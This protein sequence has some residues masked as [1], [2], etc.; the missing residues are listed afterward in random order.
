M[1]AGRSSAS[2]IVID[3]INASRSHAELRC[4]TQGQ[5]L[6][7]DLGSTNGTFVNGQRITTRPLMEGDRIAIGTTDLMFSLH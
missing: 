1:I 3:D 2:D 4:D 5:W 7:T 6:I